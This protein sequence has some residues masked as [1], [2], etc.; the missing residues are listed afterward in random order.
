MKRK[1]PRRT[2][3]V[4]PYQAAEEAVGA[5]DPGCSIAGVTKGQFS[6]LDL[7]RAVSVQTGP[8]AL[9]LSTWSTGIRDN[10]NVSLLLERGVFTSVML[11]LDRSFAARQPGYV[12]DVVRVWGNENIRVTHNHAKFF[13]LRNE[14][15]NICCRSSMNLN[16][17]P[18]L[19]QF[20]I[21][22]SLELCEFFAEI[23]REIY[24]KIPPGLIS[25]SAQSDLDFADLLGGGIS[26]QYSFEDVQQF[27]SS[28]LDIG[29]KLDLE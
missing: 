16:R 10:V 15:W 28:T 17:N 26:D 13:M 23:V 21:D 24:V 5:I 20:D 7:I 12:K 18:R 11:L 6:L 8:A 3:V 2:I 27:N 1:S 4:A 25:E 9:T 19:E 22:D 29:L 14:R